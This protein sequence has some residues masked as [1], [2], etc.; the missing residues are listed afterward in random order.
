MA[1]YTFRIIVFS[2]T[3]TK[4]QALNIVLSKVWLQQR[5]IGVNPEF[6]RHCSSN[7]SLVLALWNVLFDVPRR[8]SGTHFPRL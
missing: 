1:L 3:S 5:L 8:L 7:R 2:P 6:N 4:P